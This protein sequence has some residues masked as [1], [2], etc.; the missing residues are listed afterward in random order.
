MP[1]PTTTP[2]AQG[3][4]DQDL[5]IAGNVMSMSEVIIEVCSRVS[6]EQVLGDIRSRHVASRIEPEQELILASNG[7]DDE[8]LGA[9]KDPANLLTAPQQVAYM[10][11]VSRPVP[12]PNKSVP[13]VAIR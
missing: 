1:V 8:L 4:T 13:A 9:L 12:A 6:K 2:G 3:P 7:A 5:R 10:R 11:L